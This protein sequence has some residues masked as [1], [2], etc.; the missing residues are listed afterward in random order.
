M[1]NFLKTQYNIDATTI[2]QMTTGAGGKTYKVTSIDKNYLLKLTKE[3]G[4]NHP[5]IEPFVCEKLS[6]CG[7]FVPKFV[8]N[9][10]NAYSCELDGYVANVYEF[11]EGKTVQHNSLD[12]KIVNE[13]ATLLAK[14]HVN[15]RKFALPEGISQ[16]FFHF[17]TPQRAEKSYQKSLAKAI[18]LG[19]EEI[20]CYIKARIDLLQHIENWKFDASKLTC[21]NS[22]GDFTNNQIVLGNHTNIIDFTSCCK[23]PVVWELVRFFLHTDKS[24]TDGKIDK[25][26]F[27]EYLSCYTKIA[28]LNNYDLENMFKVYFYQVLVCDYYAQYFDEQDPVKRAD[29]LMQANFAS[30]AIVANADLIKSM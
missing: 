16:G 24:A 6:K 30:K 13:C 15:L 12:T 27:E 7:I 1:K 29:Y 18:A 11:V 10:H 4:M 20:A 21:C 23:Q 28:P 19:N 8:K 2:K 9:V 5:Q 26:R 25:M 3:D 22:H 17:M 14:I